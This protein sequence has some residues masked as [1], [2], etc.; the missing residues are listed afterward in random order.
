MISD[1]RNIHLLEGSNPSLE[2]RN[3]SNYMN[4]YSRKILFWWG[5]N[6][7]SIQVQETIWDPSYYNDILRSDFYWTFII[8]SIMWILKNKEKNFI[9]AIFLVKVQKSE[10]ILLF[11][12]YIIRLITNWT[13]HFTKAISVLPWNEW[14]YSCK[15]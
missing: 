7:I 3:V 11:T 15:N 8:D 10:K 1:Q 14:V 9:N 5:T 2:I 13:L 4:L 12:N 6:T